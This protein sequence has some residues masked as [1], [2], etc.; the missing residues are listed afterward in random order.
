MYTLFDLSIWISIIFY[1]SGI[2][3][4]YLKKNKFSHIF[5]I[6]GW[7]F[8]GIFW[9]SLPVDFFEKSDYFNGILTAVSSFL[10]WSVALIEIKY[11]KKFDKEL[12]YLS[13][14]AGFA[15]LFYFP[16]NFLST[17]HPT[18]IQKIVAHHTFFI[19]HTLGVPVK[20]N[21]NIISFSK[22]GLKIIE[23]TFACT[24][25]GSMSLFIGAILPSSD[26]LKRKIKVILVS[27]LIIYFLNLLRN[28]FVVYATGNNL[29]EKWNILGISG[30]FNIAH[31]VF[32][33][34]GSLIALILIAYYVLSELP[35]LRDMI[36][37][38]IEL[39]SEV[40]KELVEQ[41]K[42]R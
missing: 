31:N 26:E 6:L 10:A 38:L 36:F 14:A 21:N 25:L 35:E 23:I 22:N 13:K 42:N 30:S 27:V 7:I 34:L 40:R 39:P 37:K 24:G 3:S 2:I 29:F 8:L 11:H 41:K 19:L 20:L 17:I 28:A 16:Y 18:F 5:F 32:A 12:S 15:T 1:F 9:F 4:S 33:K